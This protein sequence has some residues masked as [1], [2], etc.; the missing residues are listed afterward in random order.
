VTGVAVERFGS[1]GGDDVLQVTLTG[2]DGTEAK[3]ITWGA[4]IRDLRV[5]T[6]SG[7]QRVVLGLNSVED[8]AAHSPYFGAVVG[9]YANRIGSARFNLDGQTVAVTPNEGRHALHGGPAGFGTRVWSLVDHREDSATLALVSPDGDMGYP[10]RLVATCTYRFVGPGTLRIEL[11][12]VCDR[13]TPVNLT[14]HSY[15]NLDGSAD[16]CSH[17][18]LIAA[19]HVTPTDRELIPTGEVTRVEGTDYDF[20]SLRPIGAAQLMTCRTAYDINYVLRHEPNRLAHAATLASRRSGV[21]MELWTTEP[22][23][24]F[25]DGHLLAMPVPGLDGAKYGARAGLCLEPQ[26]FPDGPNRSHFPPSIL[27]PGE[28][29]RQVSQL[30]F[31][32]AGA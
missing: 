16:I 9:R 5:P 3:I 14:T 24:Q 21:A 31:T 23:V 12:A 6:P 26:R 1:H 17:H 2:A 13:A 7:L 8:Y 4:V 11:D 10:G 25:Y 30:R 15:F 19:D 28:V 32:N 18:L 29:S 27:R 22:G 20:R